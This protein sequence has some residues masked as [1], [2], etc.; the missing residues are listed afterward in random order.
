MSTQLKTLFL[1]TKANQFQAFLA[2][3][4]LVTGIFVML[5]LL[6]SAWVSYHLSSRIQGTTTDLTPSQILAFTNL[7]RTKAGINT[8]TPN[9][10]LT[11]AAQAK[12]E[13]MLTTG[14]F[15]H[16]Y[17]SGENTINPWQ[18]IL[19]AGYQYSHAG[20]NLGKSFHS[21]QELVQAWMD[22]P[23]HKANL[24]SPDYTEIGVA[25]VDG[26][27]KDKAYDTVIVQLFATP[28][29]PGQISIQPEEFDR[30]N[31]APL[32]QKQDSWVAGFFNQYPLFL[33]LMTSII[34]AVVGLTILVDLTKGKKLRRHNPSSDLWLH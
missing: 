7:E 17:Q 12:A 19:E 33:F 3:P 27:F 10:L 4:T 21:S 24:L 1:P 5:L 34:T 15:D 13:N 25:V 23:S 11:A 29:G 9:D 16:Y 32:I 26:P 2:R 31:I 18:F 30:V 28:A 22:S 8:L 6:N 14:N 20:E